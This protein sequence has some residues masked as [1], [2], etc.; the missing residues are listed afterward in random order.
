MIRKTLLLIFI[1]TLFSVTVSAE[2]IKWLVR[3]E[4]DAIDYFSETLF[5]CKKNG[6][7]QIVDLKGN[8]VS[9]S[10][11]SITDFHEGIAL[12]LDRHKNAFRIIGLFKEKGN[13]FDP[14]DGNYY[15]GQYSFFSEGLLSVIDASN[16]KCGYMDTSGHV[17]IPCKY[18]QAR[19][20]SHGWASVEPSRKRKRTKYIN[21]KQETLKIKGF[22]HGVVIMGSSF[23]ADRRALVSYYDNDN[24]VIKIVEKDGKYVGEIDPT[25][26]RNYDN[27]PVRSCDFA[28]N[29]NGRSCVKEKNKNPSFDSSITKF[30]SELLFGY[31]KGNGIVAPAQFT[32]ADDFARGNAI[33][34][35][36]G[37]YGIVSIVEGNVGGGLS[38]DKLV[39]HGQLEPDSLVYSI[40]IPQSL[41]GRTLQMRF[42]KGDGKLTFVPLQGNAYHFAPVVKGKQSI[43][44]AQIFVDDLM[45]WDHIDTL[46]AI[47]LK[48]GGPTL[49]STKARQNKE[50]K[51]Y[52]I[53]VESIVNNDSD[54]PVEIEE[55]VFE[56]KA[57][58]GSDKKN[59]SKKRTKI[60][61]QP[62]NKTTLRCK[63]IVHPRESS[64][65]A[66]CVV[67]AN[68]I[69]Y[70]SEQKT[71]DFRP[72]YGK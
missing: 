63:I 45:L 23:N 39:L 54:V 51:E 56:T 55:Y 59:T 47:N 46:N 30:S 10:F 15:A 58:N 19:P 20:F 70:E 18:R 65:K 60:N 72:F 3:P 57:T 53:E 21:A 13:R 67:T 44:R 25:Y 27:S 36:N 52:Y 24:A 32:Y 35:V 11:D 49:V 64:I 42:D 37:K 7:F 61:L 2:T 29:P 22:H 41:K 6:E 9:P 5:K 8:V 38:S 66:T 1:L 50:K 69:K 14:I 68:G 31:K 26:K 4:Y 48:V 34:A 43:I 12:V 16:Y 17:I 71:L 40:D 33:V 62:H 28:F